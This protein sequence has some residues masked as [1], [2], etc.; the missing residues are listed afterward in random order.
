VPE[1]RWIS[2]RY[3]GS[4]G[5]ILKERKRLTREEGR[6]GGTHA[7]VDLGEQREPRKG[8]RTMTEKNASLKEKNGE[9]RE[10]R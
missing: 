1:V 5:N 2:I 9:L 10:F 3:R 8:R 4:R 6:E 7:I